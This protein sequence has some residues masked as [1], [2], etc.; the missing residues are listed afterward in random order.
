MYRYNAM[1]IGVFELLAD[2]RERIRVVQAGID[3]LEGFWLADAA[4]EAVI[5]G[6]GGG[7]E[8]AGPAPQGEARDAGH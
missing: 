1:L 3:A 2:A 5:M 6:T 7:G 4:L 8:L